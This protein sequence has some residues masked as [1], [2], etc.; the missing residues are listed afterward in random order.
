MR[1]MLDA[2]VLLTCMGLLLG[3]C[4]ASDRQTDRHT[5][6]P[7]ATAAPTAQADAA[8][9][10]PVASGNARP[11]AEPAAPDAGPY[12]PPPEDAPAADAPADAGAKRPLGTIEDWVRAYEGSSQPETKKPPRL[13]VLADLPDLPKAKLVYVRSAQIVRVDLPGGKET[14]LTQGKSANRAPHWT[15]DGR[16]IFFLSNRDGSV[17]KVFRMQADGSDAQPVTKALQSIYG[18][19]LWSVSDDGTRVAYVRKADAAGMDLSMELHVVDVATGADEIV[20]RGDDLDDPCFSRDGKLL[21]IVEGWSTVYDRRIVAVDLV[22]RQVSKLPRL[23]IMQVQDNYGG[24]VHTVRGVGEIKGLHDLGDGRLLFAASGDP[25]MA[26]RS[27][28]LYAM[29]L[30]G[31]AWS[32]LGDFAVPIG[33][34]D[35]VPDPDAKTLALAWSTR[36]GGFGADWRMEVSVMP[37]GGGAAQPKA[38][39]AAFPRPFYS[40]ADPAWAPDG[41]HLAFVLSLCPYAGCKPNIRSVVIVDTRAPA[42]RLAFVGYGGSP[43]FARAE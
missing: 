37:I 14:L 26:G 32:A 17:D 20:H 24:S 28:R 13:G 21:F 43:A 16:T 7:A 29:P 27:P 30:R 31:G 18:F 33:W 9:P 35:A 40:A 5:T 34:L 36:E 11:T 8:P 2:R 19:V 4:R 25:S 38:L 22:T 3:S 42:P 39:T 41:R 10:M 12:A 23:G 6:D 15:R 1:E